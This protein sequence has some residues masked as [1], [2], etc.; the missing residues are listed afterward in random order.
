[1]KQERATE[2]LEMIELEIQSRPSPSGFEMAYQVRIAIDRI[3]F[4]I[5]HTDRV[6]QGC[7]QILEANLQ[8]LDALDRLQSAER[9]FQESWRKRNCDQDSKRIGRV[10]DAATESSSAGSGDTLA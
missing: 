5:Q 10:P 2:F 6:A 4:A 8:L 3:R 1:M 9:H 7:G